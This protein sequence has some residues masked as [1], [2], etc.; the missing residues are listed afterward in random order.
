MPSDFLHGA[1]SGGQG[2]SAY[3]G[4]IAVDFGG[5]REA[6]AFLLHNLISK[7]EARG[8]WGGEGGPSLDHYNGK[9]GDGGNAFGGA[10]YVDAGTSAKPGFN[11]LGG[12]ITMATAYGGHGGRGGDTPGARGS[13]GGS[14]GNGGWGGDAFGGGI[15]LGGV[16]RGSLNSTWSLIDLAINACVANS[17]YGADGGDGFSG[18]DGG[19]SG[20][21]QGG[22]V[23]TEF[24]GKVRILRSSILDNDV[25]RGLGGQ[26]G[27]GFIGALDGKKGKATN[28]YGPGMA[29]GQ[30]SGV[31][32]VVDTVIESKKSKINLYVFDPMNRVV[33]S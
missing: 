29:V 1:N 25:I 18:G 7:S 30:S 16:S 22:G 26:G 33:Y 4:A 24:G 6:N 10:I 28:V 11:V 23:F 21:A 27:K 9:G 13:F 17:A 19:D 31:V 3:G 2:G 32:E 15:Y 8:W 5:S 20:R 14:G 12:T